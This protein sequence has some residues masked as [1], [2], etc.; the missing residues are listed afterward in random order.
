MA[1]RLLPGPAWG[2]SP[3][4]FPKTAVPKP[5]WRSRGDFPVVES[6]A[7][8]YRLGVHTPSK[9]TQDPLPVEG[10][11][12]GASLLLRSQVPQMVQAGLLLELSTCRRHSI[13]FICLF[14]GS[15]LHPSGKYLLSANCT[16]PLDPGS[17]CRKQLEALQAEQRCRSRQSGLGSTFGHHAVVVEYWTTASEKHG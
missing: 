15:F 8:T 14:Y 10:A 4:R 6:R 16:G 2:S 11:G 9:M 3:G 17:L 5:C 12:L 13:P 1:A 7:Q